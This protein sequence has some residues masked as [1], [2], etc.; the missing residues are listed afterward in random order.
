[1]TTILIYALDGAPRITHIRAFENLEERARLRANGYRAGVWPPKFGPEQILDATS[2]IGLPE[3]L[4]P[5][6]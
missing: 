2:V 6:H 1:M 5:L 3:A 4:S